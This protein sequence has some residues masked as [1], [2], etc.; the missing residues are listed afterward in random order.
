MIFQFSNKM[1]LHLNAST[2][3]GMATGKEDRRVCEKL[4]SVGVLG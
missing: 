2:T 4:A 3:F 1:A